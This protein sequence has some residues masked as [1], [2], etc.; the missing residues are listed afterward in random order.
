M[1]AYAG[2][3]D[4]AAQPRLRL[5]RHEQEVTWPQ[6]EIPR[7]EERGGRGGAGIRLYTLF[8]EP[9]MAYM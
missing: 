5:A 6:G 2:A 8:I 4:A 9:Y 1:H 3:R 7:A